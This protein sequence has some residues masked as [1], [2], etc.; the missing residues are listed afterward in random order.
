MDYRATAYEEYFDQ[1]GCVIQL[2]ENFFTSL[3]DAGLMNSATI[4]IHGDHGSRI[5][6]HDH[7]VNH[8]DTLTMT[9]YVDSYSTLF[10]IRS[11]NIEPGYDGQMRPLPNLFAEYLLNVPPPMKNNVYF[12]RNTTPASGDPVL[13]A[14]PMPEF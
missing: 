12:R 9:D 3:D 8:F 11:P 7:I 13:R 2:R 10:V 6:M 5:T 4:I 1:I 14:V